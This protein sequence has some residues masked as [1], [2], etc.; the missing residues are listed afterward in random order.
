M[1]LGPN[2]EKRGCSRT[3]QTTRGGHLRGQSLKGFSTSRYD[4]LSLRV[5]SVKKVVEI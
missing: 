5:A 4:M 1:I 3:T 2:V